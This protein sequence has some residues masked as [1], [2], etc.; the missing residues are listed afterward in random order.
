MQSI[1]YQQR[2][3]YSKDWDSFVYAQSVQRLLCRRYNT[4]VQVGFAPHSICLAVL[5][6][7]NGPR[8]LPPD[9]EA[10]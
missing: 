3:K 5:S 10:K 1:S 6:G 9:D 4:Y 8:G 2:R 7:E